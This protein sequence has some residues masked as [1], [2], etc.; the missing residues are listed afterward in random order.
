MAAQ[1]P[2]YEI[3]HAFWLIRRLILIGA[4]FA[5]Y[6]FIF[7]KKP[8]QFSKMSAHQFPLS[9]ANGDSHGCSAWIGK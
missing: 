6:F 5:F 4:A 8:N 9:D 7:E 2:Q 1:E 3:S